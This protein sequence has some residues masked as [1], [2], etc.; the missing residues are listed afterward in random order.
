[1]LFRSNTNP[2]AQETTAED[3]LA[4]TEDTYEVR[5][6]EQ[7]RFTVLR[8]LDRFDEG[9]E[10]LNPQ[11][12]KAW[13][14]KQAQQTEKPLLDGEDYELWLVTKKRTASGAVV[15]I[16]RQLLMFDVIEGQPFPARDDQ[17]TEQ[18]ATSS[19]LQPVAPEDLP[20][21]PA[22]QEQAQPAAPR[23]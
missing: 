5:Q 20:P 4:V 1:M 10:L 7:G 23:S 9:E 15:R 6:S 3:S 17:S 18:S 16:E 14:Q 8:Q 12:L 21:Q 11:A 19:Q 22:P 2:Q 13:V